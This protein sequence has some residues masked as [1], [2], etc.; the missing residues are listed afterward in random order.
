MVRIRVKQSVHSSE[1]YA[2]FISFDYNEEIL[3]I[4]R[5]F[6]ERHWLKIYKQ[7]E[8]PVSY[9]ELVISKLCKYDIELSGRYIEIQRDPVV[10]VEDFNFKTKPFEHQLESFRY[11]MTH[12]RWFLGDEQG[13]GKTKQAIDIA[14]AK[15]QIGYKHCLIICGVNGLKWNWVNE[16]HTHSDEEA[17]ILGQR[18]KKRTGE[19][20][21][22]SSKDK[23]ADLDA[24]GDIEAYFIITNIESLR[25]DDIL[26]GI[27]S[28]I[29]QEDIG[30]IVVDEIHKMKDPGSQQGKA[31]L[32]LQSKYRIAMT[33]TPLM[34]TPLDLFIILK[35]LGYESHSFYQF[36]QYYAVMGGYGGYQVVGYKHLDELQEQLDTFMVRRLKEDVLDLPEKIYIDEYVDMT[37]KQAIIYK[38]VKAE[39]K[40]N[41]DKLAISPNPLA[42]MIR[43]R[44]ATGFTG[45]LSSDI[46]ESA[47]LDRMEEI[48][49]E[50]VL[51]NR[52]VVIF[53]NWTQ[54]T[55][56]IYEKL[57]PHQYGIKCITGET[58]D[59]DRQK[60]V[61]AFQN[62]DM[63]RVLIGTIGAM[64]TGL[65][66]TAGTVVIFMDHPWNRALYD[67][68][69]DRCHRIGQSNKIT[70]YNIMCKSTIDERVWKLVQ[71]KGE[72]SDIL[73]D[74][75]LADGKRE[76][77]DYLLS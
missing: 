63:C 55:D 31:F 58:A 25:N 23:I 17:Y 75:Q 46:K 4:V 27:Q 72:M 70:I 16:V 26:A 9:F 22:G 29:K 30:M 68:A 65:T 57:F 59:E 34:N 14:V 48:V 53:S 62:T 54:M 42:E 44:Q 52:K 11:G 66:L 7:W 61:D 5:A 15:K 33:G 67:Q 2:L 20:Y 41:I 74:G 32:K 56:A 71:R 45:I 10:E 76:L 36:K 47:K 24:L 40:S 51:N 12:D 28:W 6:P 43:M 3:N 19:I 69:V 39:I 50:S 1:Q 18:I 77:I 73:V 64:G 21:I 49:E 8:V 38:E 35:W 60:V 13:L 37:A